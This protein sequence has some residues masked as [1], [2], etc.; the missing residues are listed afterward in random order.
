M[1]LNVSLGN[2]LLFFLKAVMV[3]QS[4]TGLFLWIIKKV[5]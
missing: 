1:M 3:H 2:D 5:C 4:L